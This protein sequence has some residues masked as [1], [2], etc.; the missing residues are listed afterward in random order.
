MSTKSDVKEKIDHV[1]DKAKDAI[2]KASDGAKDAATKREISS[3]TLARRLGT[4]PINR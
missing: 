2:E 4:P 1:T 3:K